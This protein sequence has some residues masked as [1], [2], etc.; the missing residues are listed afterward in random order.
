M[1][2]SLRLQKYDHFFTKYGIYRIDTH[3]TL[4]ATGEDQ[5]PRFDM[6]WQVATLYEDRAQ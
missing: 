2:S 5:N 1:M 3:V 4:V 6:P